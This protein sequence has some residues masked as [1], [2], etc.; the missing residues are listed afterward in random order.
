MYSTSTYSPTI[1]FSL[2]SV[3]KSILSDMSIATPVISVISFYV[4]Y[5][6]TSPHVQSLCALNPEVSLVIFKVVMI[7][8]LSAILSLLF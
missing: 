1:L 4:K 3:L 2:A 6:I 8:V 5:L 7:A